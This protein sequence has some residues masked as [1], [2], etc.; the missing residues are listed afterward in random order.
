MWVQG[1]H[2]RTEVYFADLLA[3]EPKIQRI[4]DDYRKAIVTKTSPKAIK[5]AVDNVILETGRLFGRVRFNQDWR[6]LFGTDESNIPNATQRW[7]EW[8]NAQ[9]LSYRK[10]YYDPVV[11]S[12]CIMGADE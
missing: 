5:D 10:L 3:V 7:D 2:G 6:T 1:E 8:I 4:R 12:G 9:P 11:V